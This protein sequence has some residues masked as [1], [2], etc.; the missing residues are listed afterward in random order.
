MKLLLTGDLH[1]GRTSTRVPAHWASSARTLSAWERLVRTAKE[2]AVSAVLLSGDLLDHGN[3]YWE[4]IGPFE[5]G[6]QEL[7]NAGIDVIA[8][9]GNHD[10]S[11]LPSVARTL[12]ETRFRL[13]GENGQWERITLSENGQPCLH[14]DG[15]SFPSEQVY[16]DPTLSYPAAADGLPVLGMVHG[17][18]GIANSSYAPL[19]MQRLQSL[20]LTG[21]LLGHI[22]KPSLTPGSPWVLMP[23]SPHPLDPGE[24]DAHHA[25]ITEVVQG[26][27]TPPEPC[28][29]AGIRYSDLTLPLDE[30]TPPTH[31]VLRERIQAEIRTLRSSARHVLRVTLSGTTRDPEALQE[32]VA[33]MTQQEIDENWTLDRIRVTATPPLDLE[34][35]RQTGPIQALLADALE[36]PPP[37]LEAR[38]RHLLEDLQQQIHYDNK[39]LS[40]LTL[41]DAPLRQTLTGILQHLMQEPPA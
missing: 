26:R 29:P 9:S 38:I 19:D 4:T 33:Q 12:R 3:H 17:D 24:P 23:G 25:W 32:M 2:Q 28:C 10:V 6:V 21:W 37:E 41:E 18:P 27:L 7:S 14:I 5:K 31:D 22:H 40:R 1:L 30:D 34:A 11:I 13:L 39:N 36:N 15:W 20:P 35:A 16:T 8:V